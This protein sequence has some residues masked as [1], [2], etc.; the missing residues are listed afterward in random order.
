MI[1][2][3]GVAALVLGSGR[4]AAVIGLMGTVWAAPGLPAVG[5]PIGDAATYPFA[6]LGSALGWALLAVIAARRAV[7]SPIADWW[8]FWREMTAVYLAVLVG[9]GVGVAIAAWRLGGQLL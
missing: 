8:D 2:A 9:A 3:I 5:A 4:L 7:R 1:G 6:V